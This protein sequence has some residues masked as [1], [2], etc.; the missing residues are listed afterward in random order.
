VWQQALF[1]GY[2]YVAFRRHRHHTS[3]AREIDESWRRL[4]HHT[5]REK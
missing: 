5:A 3:L 4:L 1:A 2:G